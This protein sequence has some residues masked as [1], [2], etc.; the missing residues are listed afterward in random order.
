[1]RQRFGVALTFLMLGA[2]GGCD[3]QPPNAGTGGVGG[4]G[5][6]AGTG[7]AP[8][9]GVT[10]NDG[11]PCTD[12]ACD[13]SEGCTFVPNQLPCD[14]SNACT[15]GDQCV[16]GVCLGTEIVCVDGNPCTLDACIPSVGC[17]FS[18]MSG[19]CDDGNACN[20]EDRCSAGTCL[21]TLITC[22]DD[23]PCTDDAC[24]PSKGCSFVFNQLPCDDGSACTVGDQCSAGA[25]SGSAITCADGNPCTSDSCVAAT[26]CVFSP[27]S[28]P[29][30]DGNICTIGDICVA[31]ACAPGT[32]LSCDDQSSCTAEA[33]NPLSGCTYEYLCDA[34]ASC[35]AAACECESGYEGDGYSCTLEA[36]VC[37]DGRCT[38]SETVVTFP[39]DCNHDLVVVVE[40]ALADVLNQSLQVYL[41]DLEREGYLARVEPWTPWT[42]QDLKALLFQQVDDYGVEGALLIGNLPAAWYEQVAF[43]KHEEFPLDLFL[44]DR[45]ATWTDVDAD[46][47]YDAHSELELE[48]FVSRLRLETDVVSP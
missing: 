33:C 9:A 38:G 15:S 43:G 24:E 2:L 22:K 28:D 14:D 23:N 18:P 48:I 44:E 36:P 21:G 19:P 16:S 46:G 40:A 47:I 34:H 42:V 31:G 13:P 41:A 35:V 45:E 29:C 11:N 8:C 39:G 6:E 30:D 7:G 4:V 25:W 3:E 12:D 5:G 27:M 10:C 20:G 17:R 32:P 26:G 37:P 1:M